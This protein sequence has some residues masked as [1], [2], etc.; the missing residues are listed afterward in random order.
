M[1]I[2]IIKDGRISEIG[3]YTT[4]FPNISFAPEGPDDEFMKANSALRV[5]IWKQHD[6]KT[7]KLI[8]SEPYIEDNQVFIVQVVDKTSDEIVADTIQEAATIRAIRDVLLANTD[9]SQA[10]KSTADKEAYAA[11]RQALRDITLQESFPYNIEWPV[12]PE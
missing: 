9:W 6:S 2:A 11:Y 4:L 1:D 12:Q 3:D 8:S 5:A 10:A 7:Q